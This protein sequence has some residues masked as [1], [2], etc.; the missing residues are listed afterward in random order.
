MHKTFAKP[1]QTGSQDGVGDGTQIP[2]PDCRA[3]GYIS[4]WEKEG[5]VSSKC[6]APDKQLRPQWKTTQRRAFGQHK[7][8]LV[9]KKT[10]SGRGGG[11]GESGKSQKK[12]G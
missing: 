4:F 2:A 6:A 10:Q 5:S 7:V 12:K 8:L 1:S 11:R 3:M 9:G